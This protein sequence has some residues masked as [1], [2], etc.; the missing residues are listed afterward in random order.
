MVL[1]R[2][3]GESRFTEMLIGDR[4]R[5]AEYK[6]VLSGLISEELLSLITTDE[7]M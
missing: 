6:D 4:E 1:R 7:K 2:K 3:F 5:L